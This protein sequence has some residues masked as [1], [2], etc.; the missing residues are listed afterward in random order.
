MTAAITVTRTP[1]STIAATVLFDCG[2][3][4]FSCGT[5][6]GV[7]VGVADAMGEFVGAGDVSM[8]VPVG[9]GGGV[10][11]GEGVGVGVAGT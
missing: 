5:Y 2:A 7:A 3:P 11:V 9:E 10:C 6:C 8:L 1:I 4:P